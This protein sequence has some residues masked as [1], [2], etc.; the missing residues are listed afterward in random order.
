LRDV[1]CLL[2]KWPEHRL[3]DLAPVHWNE[4]SARDDVR[5]LLDENRFRRVTLD[6]PR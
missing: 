2:P 1:F 5:A 3:L 4:T 6:V